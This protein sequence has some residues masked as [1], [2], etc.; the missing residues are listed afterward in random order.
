MVWSFQPQGLAHHLWPLCAPS[1]C[2]WCG[3]CNHK[4]WLT[5]CDLFVPH[6]YVSGMVISTTRPDTLF[7]PCLCLISWSVVWS[8]QPQ[9]LAHHVWPLC[10]PS[11]CKWCGHFNHKAWLTICGPVVPHQIV[12]D[13]VIST[14]RLGSPFVAPL[15]PI[16]Q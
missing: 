15:W 4:A 6:Q 13:V 11:D 10:A 14:T 16:R 1:A 9:G 8:F 3:H 2:K 5:I 12:S 7:M